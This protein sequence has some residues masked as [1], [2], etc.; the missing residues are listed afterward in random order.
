MPNSQ[1][2]FQLSMN[3][4]NMNGFKEILTLKQLHSV[5]DRS[6]VRLIRNGKSVILKNR[7]VCPGRYEVW[8]EDERV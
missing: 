6:G 4:W 2:N 3:H 5:I 8:L 7:R 1:D